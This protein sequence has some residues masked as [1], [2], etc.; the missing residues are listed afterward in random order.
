MADY[1]TAV[2]GS[3][4]GATLAEQLELAESD[5]TERPLFPLDAA[6]LRGQEE[7]Q[8]SRLAGGA[9][10][11]TLHSPPTLRSFR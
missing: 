6:A 3:P 4:A 10:N 5:S 11:Q 7:Q 9:R 1:M 2:K 8:T